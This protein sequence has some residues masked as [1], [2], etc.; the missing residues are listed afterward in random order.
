MLWEP[1]PHSSPGLIDGSN[2]TTS[3]TTWGLIAESLIASPV[4]A[5]CEGAELVTAGG[6]G[7]GGEPERL[8]AGRCA[9]PW[10]GGGVGASSGLIREH[11]P[12]QIPQP[13]IRS[14]LRTQG[15]SNTSILCWPPWSPPLLGAPGGKA[16]NPFNL[17]ETFHQGRSEFLS[18]LM[19]GKGR[20]LATVRQNQKDKQ[21][22]SLGRTI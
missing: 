11:P 22:A 15:Q 6:G 8:E 3:I 10:S 19:K 21:F 17:F 1:S 4:R 16:G 14:F 7:L 18:P 9:T 20:G 13:P 2:Q 12:G 5:R